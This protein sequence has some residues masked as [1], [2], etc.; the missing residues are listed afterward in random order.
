VTQYK[1]EIS[2][3]SSCSYLNQTEQVPKG[4]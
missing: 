1:L 4:I 3:A 2:I